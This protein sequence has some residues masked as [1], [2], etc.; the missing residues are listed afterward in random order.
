MTRLLRHLLRILLAVVLYWAGAMFVVIAVRHCGG[1]LR[2]DS[3]LVGVGCF[4]A[5]ILLFRRFP[6]IPMYIFGHE[7]THYLAAKLF[8]KETGKIR[9]GRG[10][11]SVEVSQPNAWIVLAPYFVPFY[12]LVSLLVFLGMKWL[13]RGMPR[14]VCLAFGGMVGLGWAYHLVMT[15][16]AL[17]EG[18]QDIALHGAFF[19][20]GMILA[21]NAFCLMAGVLT[22]TSSWGS[23]WGM[24]RDM[25]QI[26]LAAIQSAFADR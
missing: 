9:L 16:K 4:V 15:L 18:Q 2:M 5:G 13:W 20:Y 22:L 26:Q 3:V 12:V 23:A 19:S 6:F 14:E 10:K 25:T 17:R 1:S 7:M 11:G 24:F 8:L 21:G